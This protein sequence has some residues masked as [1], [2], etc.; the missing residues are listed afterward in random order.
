MKYLFKKKVW[1]KINFYWINKI[2]NHFNK[3][4]L[5]FLI[6]KVCLN[7]NSLKIIVLLI[8]MKVLII[9]IILKII[10]NLNK[11]NQIVLVIVKGIVKL[12]NKAKKINKIR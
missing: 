1:V 6:I 5:L 12:I 11:H 9:W 4:I 2:S 8:M 7:L 3:T 10:K